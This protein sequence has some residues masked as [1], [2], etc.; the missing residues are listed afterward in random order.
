M[1][2][3]RSILNGANIGGDGSQGGS[4][5]NPTL[6]VF[7]RGVVLHTLNDPSLRNLEKDEKLLETIR[8]KADYFRSPRNSIICRIVADQLGKTKNADYVCFPFFSSHLMMPVKP[9][10]HVWLLKEQPD[11]LTEMY[12]WISRIPEPIDVEDVNYTH[13]SR[14]FQYY[15]EK[16]KDE[17]D[18]GSGNFSSKRVLTFLNGSPLVETNVPIA[19]D[20]RAYVSI[21][22]GSKESELFTFEPVPRFTKRPGDLVL[23]GS[24]NSTITLGTLFGWG[25][26]R[27]ASNTKTSA[28]A[29]ANL[30]SSSSLKKTEYGSI[31]IVTGRGRIFQDLATEV[32]D[33]KSRDKPADGSTKPFI[34]K[35]EFGFEVDKNVATQQK[36]KN[37]SDPFLGQGNAQTNPQEGNPDFFLDASR[38]LLASKAD[39]DVIFNTG[40][41]G[42]AS[43]FSGQSADMNGSAVAVKSDH[44][45]IV[46]RKNDTTNGS[47]R[48]LKE[49]AGDGDRASI[50]IEPNG[51]IQ[52][53]GAKIFI[54][55]TTEDGGKGGGPADGGSHPYVRYQELE[56]LWFDTMDAMKDFCTTLM[57]HFVPVTGPDPQITKAAVELNAKVVGLKSRISDVKSKRVFGE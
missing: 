9:G 42:V 40:K 13:S 31:D 15:R 52:I 25:S 22:T 36:G 11:S 3:T 48:I 26:D 21:I 49:G 10:E 32:G 55:R 54:G 44:V 23:Q 45:R 57:T 1:T 56:N 51:D 24:N 39:I 4:G 27:P 20:D 7:N 28:A 17:P 29:G 19:G 12:Y 33:P 41:S 35:N 5:V 30:L 46:A 53:S 43:S 37:E 6:R 50:V 34:V 14:K 8:N 38:I 47:I 16:E 2:A 18:D